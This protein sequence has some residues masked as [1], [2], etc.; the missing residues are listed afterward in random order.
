PGER[1]PVREQYL[2]PDPKR[3]GRTWQRFLALLRAEGYVVEHRILCAADFGAPTTRERLFL[4]ARRDG[5][6]IRW[7]EPTHHRKPAK[8]QK[9]WRA[10]AEWID[11]S[12]EC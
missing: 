8:G 10:A 9:R 3:A 6:P 2:I 4:V 7:P 5:L 11:W 12:I 1:V